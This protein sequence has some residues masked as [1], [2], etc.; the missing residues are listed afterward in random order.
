MLTIRGVPFREGERV[1]II[2]V[3]MPRTLTNENHYPLRG[4]PFRYVGPFESV[5]EGD[6]DVL[7]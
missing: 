4:K 5:A 2:I 3:S 7:R 1:E 6:W